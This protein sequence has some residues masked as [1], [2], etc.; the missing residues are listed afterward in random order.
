MLSYFDFKIFTAAFLRVLPNKLGG[1]LTTS[2]K[3]DIENNC[4]VLDG[5][6]FMNLWVKFAKIN[7]LLMENAKEF[8][9]FSSFGIS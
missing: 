2:C 1:I 4:A 9:I 6:E 5:F 7:N 3:V 8:H